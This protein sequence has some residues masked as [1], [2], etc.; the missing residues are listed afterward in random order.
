MDSA[1]V[2][3]MNLLCLAM[4]SYPVFSKSSASYCLSEII[5]SWQDHT[6]SILTRPHQTMSHLIPILKLHSSS[7]CTLVHLRYQT[8]STSTLL[9]ASSTQNHCQAKFWPED[10]RPHYTYASQACSLP[11]GP[12]EYQHCITALI[13]LHTCRKNTTIQVI[14]SQHPRLDHSAAD[15]SRV[16]LTTSSSLACGG[17][18]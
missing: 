16:L 4:S 12:R 9:I 1:L 7:D 3:S 11:S 5:T 2:Y 15:G 17:P 8:P 18:A 14:I 13:P 6:I 10:P